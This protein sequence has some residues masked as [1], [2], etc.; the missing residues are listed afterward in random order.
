MGRRARNKQA[1]PAPLDA[2]RSTPSSKRKADALDDATSTVKPVKKVR[3]TETGVV[4]VKSKVKEGKKAKGKGSEPKGKAKS[5]AVA[6]VDDDEEG[7]E[8]MDDEAEEDLQ[9]HR[10]HVF[11]ASDEEDVGSQSG[12][13]SGLDDEGSLEDDDMLRDGNVQEL[14][15]S[16]DDDP[17]PDNAADDSEDEDDSDADSD[18]GP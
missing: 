4:K 8:D 1:P 15:F 7:W 11:E 13:L 5:K 6:P 3:P 17:A 10:K 2:K 16:D 9:A 18:D 14:Q 12:G